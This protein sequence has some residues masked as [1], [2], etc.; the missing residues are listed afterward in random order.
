MRLE[1]ECAIRAARI[2]QEMADSR[3]GSDRV[4]SKGG[5]DLVTDTDV[6]CEDAIRAE[7]LR[8]FP[9]YA[10]IGEERGGAPQD[11]HPYWL[12]DPICGTRNFASSI[13]LYCTNIALVEQGEVRLGVVGFGITKEIVYAEHNSGARLL[14]GQ[15][16]VGTRAGDSTHTIWLDGKTEQGAEAV[17]RALISRRWYVVQFPSG[18]AYAYAACGRLDAAL[19]FS[20]SAPG[21]PPSRAYGSVHSAAGCFIAREA[22]A[23]VR[24]INDG[25]DWKLSTSAFVIA[26]SERLYEEL[27]SL[28]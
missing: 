20:G 5:I 4:S 9:S 8:S 7:L 27:L 25:T 2:A 21:K 1:T 15:T 19:Q 26:G 3:R 13:P 24:D 14:N 16:E 23:I 10:V 18:L 17:K 6:A 22:G 28:F 12:V 11:G